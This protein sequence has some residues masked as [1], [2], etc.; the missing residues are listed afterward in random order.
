L[1][2]IIRRRAILGAEIGGDY[3]HEQAKKSRLSRARLRDGRAS[4]RKAKRAFLGGPRVGIGRRNGFAKNKEELCAN[5]IMAPVSVVSKFSDAIS[6][7]LR[8]L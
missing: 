6:T 8:L 3:R 2:A 5:L 1:A 4:L 7:L